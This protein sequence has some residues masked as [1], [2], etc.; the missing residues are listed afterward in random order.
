MDTR[1]PL[2][3]APSR[4]G[5]A[6]GDQPVHASPS[7]DQGRVAHAVLGTVIGDQPLGAVL[8]RIARLATEEIPGVDEASVTL[9]KNGKARSAAFTGALAVDLDERQYE[10]GFGPCLDAAVSGATVAVPDMSAETTYAAFAQEAARR[11]VTHSMSVGLPIGTSTVG[12]LNLYGLR[13]DPYGD[14]AIDGA[15]TFAGVAA[16]AV[17]NAAA[18]ADAVEE[19]EGLRA[20]MQTRA[21]I[22]QAKGMIMADRKCSADEAFRL[23]TQ[24]SNHS[25]RKLRDVA[26][27]IVEN[28]QR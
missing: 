18:L 20:A 23:L 9:L 7:T 14:V 15:R 10:T 25:N 11:G 1:E 26:R 21:V 22:E 28:A 27:S 17:A 3:E 4:P 13:G 2:D 19:A 8:E 5:G 16:I 12:G 24:A 6:V